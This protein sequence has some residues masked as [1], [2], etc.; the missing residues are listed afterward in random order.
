MLELAELSEPPDSRRPRSAGIGGSPE[1]RSRS[2]NTDERRTSM[3]LN[4]R[5]ENG[6]SMV[7]N[8]LV[9]SVER[10]RRALR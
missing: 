4:N 10:L 3:R 5:A 6:H 8:E 2:E 9:S 7:L 1:T